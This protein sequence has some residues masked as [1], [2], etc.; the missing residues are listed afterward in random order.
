[1]S[2]LVPLKQIVRGTSRSLWPINR[3]CARDLKTPVPWHPA[4][5]LRRADWPA[6]SRGN[7][8]EA[9][10]PRNARADHTRFCSPKNR[11]RQMVR[12]R[13]AAAPPLSSN[14]PQRGPANLRFCG[15]GARWPTGSQSGFSN[16]DDGNAVA[17][18]AVLSP[19][20]VKLGASRDFACRWAKSQLG[21]VDVCRCG[22]PQMGIVR[23]SG[24]CCMG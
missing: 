24:A 23:R 8:L 13:P 11:R 1:L 19:P 20:A 4:A 5:T 14:Q 10:P 18:G 17:L 3:P 2:S 21:S 9:R 6:I 7:D 16:A 12:T 22:A 15:R